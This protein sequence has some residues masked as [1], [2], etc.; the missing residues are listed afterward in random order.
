[1]STW[2]RALNERIIVADIPLHCS[3]SSNDSSCRENA[4]RRRR[5]SRLRHTALYARLETANPTFSSG[6][7]SGFINT[8]HRTS[9]P[10][11]RRPEANTRLNAACLRRACRRGFTYFSSL[12][13]SFQRP[14]ARRRERT[15]LPFFVA[16]RARKPC[17][18]FRFLL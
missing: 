4:S 15:F 10:S 18:F 11:I 6:L 12:T 13:V 14:F 8:K 16:M 5:R 3:F 2:R 9:D 1:M 17:V 7:P